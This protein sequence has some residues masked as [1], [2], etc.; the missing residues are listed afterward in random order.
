VGQVA[1]EVKL[2]GTLEVALDGVSVAPSAAKPRQLLALLAMNAGEVV[3]VSTLMAELWGYDHPRSASTTLHTYIGKLRQK[4]TLAARSS[5]DAAGDAKKILVTEPL[6]YSLMVSPDDTDIG[7]Y[8]R[9]ASPGRIAADHGDYE[10]SAE[11]LNTALELWRGPVLSDVAAGTHLAAD[12]VRLEEIRR[13]D[14]DLRI[15]ADL[16]L[17]RHRKVLAELTGLCTRFPMSENFC[18]KYMLALYRSGEQWR[19]L[20]AFHRLRTNLADELGVDPSVSMQRF[21]LAILRSDPV[22]ADYPTFL[23]GDLSLAGSAG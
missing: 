14:L 7:R 21:H 22:V 1:F 9:L 6:G 12:V 23:A 18:A 11:Y 19:A 8:E 17:G 2:L 4:L 20:D 13:G 15:E 16:R 3:P 5:A 10:T